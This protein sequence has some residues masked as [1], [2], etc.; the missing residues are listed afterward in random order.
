MFP[1]LAERRRQTAGTLSG[2][3]QQMLAMARAMAADPRVL[4]LDEVSMGLAPIVVEEIYE[5]VKRIATEDVAILI[6]EQFAH[7]I[8]DVADVAAIMLHG[9]VLLTGKP[10]EVNEALQRAYLGGSIE[11]ELEAPRA[12]R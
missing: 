11:V 1:R 8:M 12:G 6:V 4:L 10:A 7:E 2:G 9:R 5:V 3:E